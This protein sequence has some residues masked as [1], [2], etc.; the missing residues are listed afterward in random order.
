MLDLFGDEDTL[1]LAEAHRPLPG[2]FGAGRRDRATVFLGL[3]A[4]ASEAGGA[5]LGVVLGSGFEG[6]PDLM[7]E[8]A[9]RF[10][11]LGATP[12]S[13]AALK[14]PTG[15]AALCERLA[16]PHPALAGV[17]SR[18]GRAR[19]PLPLVGR[20]RGGRGAE[21]TAP[22]HPEP[23]P[24]PPS[25][26]QGGG[27]AFHPARRASA[28]PDGAQRDT[29]LLKRAGGCGGSHIRLSAT[30]AVP[31]GHYLQQKVPGRAFALN[32][33]SDGRRIEPLALTEQWQAPSR[34]RPFRYG[35]ALARGRDE[36]H[37]V[38]PAL[39][40]TIMEA[41]A[42]IVRAT[43]LTG[44]A[45]AD[46]L[47]DGESWWLLEINPRP[48][49]TLDVLDRRPTPLLLAHIEASLGRLPT[50]EPAPLDATGAEIC[51]AARSYAALPPLDWPA[52]VHDRPRAGSRVGRDAPLCTVTATGPDAAAVEKNLRERADALRARLDDTENRHEFQHDRPEPQR[53]G[54][55][56]GREPRR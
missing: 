23:P 42:R 40:E 4:L 45:S 44:L 49:A 3:E 33:L 8:I 15:F 37:P 21:R 13:V 31:P 5:P 12:A 38:P 54:E 32:F 51:Y 55:P 30:G 27:E 28:E 25:S 36:P 14:D 6:A 34:L 9:A 2:R 43:G 1:A 50:L 18:L 29:W 11:L 20:G 24:P 53:P 56:A 39:R 46:L 16:I 10:P 22:P 52:H 17:P 19:V 41:V 35:G 26:P 48:G 47:I 7:A